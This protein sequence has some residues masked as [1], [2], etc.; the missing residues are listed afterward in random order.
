MGAIFARRSAK[1]AGRLPGV[2]EFDLHLVARLHQRHI[3]RLQHYIPVESENQA[4]FMCNA[5]S[6]GRRGSA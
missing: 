3:D 1:H 4:F 2:F 5:A 6:V